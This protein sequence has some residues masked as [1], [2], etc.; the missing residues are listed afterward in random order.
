VEWLLGALAA[1]A[2]RQAP[3]VAD[4][5]AAWA[6]SG[7][8]SLTGPPEHPLVAPAGVVEAIAA[9]GAAAGV[10]ALALLGERAAC[11]GLV[12]GGE[13]SCG[14]LARLL[15]ARDGW[16]AV[17]LPRPDDWA[18]VPAWL[19]HRVEP[20]GWDEVAAAVAARGER[21]LTARARVLG[22]PV[23]AVGSV[24]AAGPAV[25]AE[26]VAPAPPADV[27]GALVVDLS[28]L[29]AG[30]L[31]GQLLQLAGARVVKVESVGRPDGARRG[32][33]A[34]YDLLH[35]GQESVALDFTSTSGREALA[36][37]VAAGDVV[38]EGSRPRALRQLGIDRAEILWHGRARA[39]VSITGYGASGDDAQRVAFGDDAAAAGGLVARHAGRP[40]FVADAVAD[41]LTGMTAAA[42]TIAAFGS[43]RWLLDVPLARVA[44]A[45]AA[46]GGDGW[47]PGRDVDAAPPRAR[48][49][50][51]RA[52]ALGADTAAVLRGHGHGQPL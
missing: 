39:W 13:V 38:I 32:S 47:R 52:R 40:C 20:G 35:G 1:A 25:R 8:M 26:R 36:A 43:G 11:A 50:A 6:A 33:A 12:R 21:E 15:R 51:G 28:S 27:A 18:D 14:G 22:L 24:S 30:P 3:P 5:D 29:W 44:A 16:L 42:A 41:P 23:A 7:A 37:L 46:R 49:A 10:D 9:I 34:F 2:P 17:N 45:V 48:A 31:C 19:E 4:A